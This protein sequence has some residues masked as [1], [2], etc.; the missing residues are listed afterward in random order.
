MDPLGYN[1]CWYTSYLV[2]QKTWEPPSLQAFVRSEPVHVRQKVEPIGYLDS[3]QAVGKDSTGWIIYT[4]HY[5]PWK[6]KTKQRTVGKGWS[7]EQ[8]FPILPSG[9]GK[10]WWLFSTSWVIVY[11]YILY[12]PWK[13]ITFWTQSHGGGWIKWFSIC[14]ERI[15]LLGFQSSIFQGCKNQQPTGRMLHGCCMSPSNR[16]HALCVAG[17]RFIG[18]IVAFE[19]RLNQGMSADMPPFY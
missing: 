16:H 15:D 2:T 8:G 5:I 3:S 4:V 10:V 6:S 14:K 18:F 1:T 19:P 9:S 17:C 13:M 7:M 12:T 11:I